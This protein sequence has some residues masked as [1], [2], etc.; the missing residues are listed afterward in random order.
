ML[1]KIAIALIAVA[2]AWLGGRALVHALVS[3]ETKIR[4]KLEDACEGFSN[5]RMSPILDF[6]AH[7]FVDQTSGHPR[8][9]VR[10]GAASVFFT[11]KDPETKKFPYRAIVVPDTLAI[12]IDKVAKDKADLRCTIRITDVRGGKDRVAW[13]FDLLGKM[14]DGEDGWQLVSSMCSTKEGGSKLQ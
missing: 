7:D 8:D 2:V 12:E 3:D 4:W 13:E 5:T 14:V 11:E 6:L 1:R 10:A 9:D